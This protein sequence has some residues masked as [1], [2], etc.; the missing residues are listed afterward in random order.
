MEKLNSEDTEKY[1]NDFNKSSKNILAKNAVTNSMIT[2]IMINT[3]NLKNQIEV[4]SNVIDTKVVASDQENSGRCWIFSLL[5]I[6]RLQMIE[7]YKL[8]DDFELSQNYLYFWHLFE[9]ANN[10]LHNVIKTKKEN[11][12]SRLMYALLEFPIS[13]GGH[14]EMLVNIVE[15]YGLM[16]KYQMKETIH[17]NDT[18]EIND[19]LNSIL[20]NYA[21]ILRTDPKSNNKEQ[22]DKMMNNVYKILVIFLGEPPKTIEWKYYKNE[23]DKQKYKYANNITPIE[24]YEKY[25]PYNLKDKVCL[26]NYPCSSKPYYNT[27]D[28]EYSS[29]MVGKNQTNYVNVPINIMKEC[30]RKSIDK[31]EAIWFGSDVGKHSNAHLGILDNKTIN[32]KNIF[33]IDFNMDKCSK[34]DYR[35]GEISHAMIIKGYD[36]P[37]DKNTVLKELNKSKAKAK[38][39][40][41]HSNKENKSGG[42]K[43]KNKKSMKKIKE[44]LNNKNVDKYLVENS[45][46]N[47]VGENDTGNFI[48]SD[49]WFDDNVYLIVVDK[50]CLS[51][52]MHK[53]IQNGNNVMLPYWSP[54]GKLMRF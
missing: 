4:F 39:K 15:K 43:S 32:Y 16:P 28:V 49:E 27:Y 45:W 3:S 5:N 10:F 14:W 23:N 29:N 13:D 50:N 48:M 47:K 34:L 6:I 1:S 52:E 54:F 18:Q 24:F 37:S 9:S 25:V 41:R 30:V 36:K 2:N 19:Y 20:R 21:H 8:D 40:S 7:T 42:S 17:S 12:E 44:Q 22:I 26:I 53:K 11:S 38:T 46:G 33:D 35:N 51:P 31:K